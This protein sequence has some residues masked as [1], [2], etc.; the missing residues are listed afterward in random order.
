LAK[1]A[2]FLCRLPAASS[3]T[4]RL[5]ASTKVVASRRT[6]LLIRLVVDP[7]HN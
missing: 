1:D 3:S 6:V 5:L 2:I 4:A 7:L